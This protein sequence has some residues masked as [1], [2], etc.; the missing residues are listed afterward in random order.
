VLCIGSAEQHGPLLL[1]ILLFLSLSLSLSLLFP[2]SQKK[3]TSQQFRCFAN[4]NFSSRDVSEKGET[5]EVMSFF[6]LV[7]TTYT[8]SISSSSF[9]CLF[10]LKFK[11]QISERALSHCFYD[12]PSRLTNIGATHQLRSLQRPLLT[13]LQQHRRPRH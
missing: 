6:R 5:D 10:V 11:I 7:H 8:S 9:C 1:F 12:A 3:P 13:W 4:C 2:P